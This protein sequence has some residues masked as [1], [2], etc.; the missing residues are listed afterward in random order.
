M[1]QEWTPEDDPQDQASRE[2]WG[3]ITGAIDTREKFEAK[4]LNWPSA[5]GRG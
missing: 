4:R 5:N 2:L 1:R 3:K